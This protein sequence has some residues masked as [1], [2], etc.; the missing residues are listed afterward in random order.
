MP[1]RVVSGVKLLSVGLWLS[2]S[3]PESVLVF[4]TVQDFPLSE[5][6]RFCSVRLPLSISRKSDR[7]GLVLCRHLILVAGR[8]WLAIVGH[9]SVSLSFFSLQLCQFVF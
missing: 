9:K 3:K 2:A 5:V 1:D 8:T 4:L 6:F 7:R